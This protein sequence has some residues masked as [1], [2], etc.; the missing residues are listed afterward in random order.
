MWKLTQWGECHFGCVE[1]AIFL[2]QKTR[3]WVSDGTV[4]VLPGMGEGHFYLEKDYIYYNPAHR[5]SF[6]DGAVAKWWE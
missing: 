5:K 1:L 3:D 2:S 6:C 4:F